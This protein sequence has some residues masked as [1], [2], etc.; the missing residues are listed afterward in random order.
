MS[1]IQED[2]RYDLHSCFH[3][4]HILLI[5]KFFMQ[6][7]LV[8]NGLNIW[9]LAVF[10]N[11]YAQGVWIWGCWR[12]LVTSRSDQTYVTLCWCCHMLQHFRLVKSHFITLRVQEGIA[13]IFMWR[14]TGV[15]VTKAPFANFSVSKIFD[16]AKVPVRFLESHSY[17]T[18]VTA[19]ELRRHQPNINVIFNS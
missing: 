7:F 12:N 5:F 19:A 4:S 17:L 2:H 6:L 1:S 9:F 10:C 11:S 18:G 8:Q 16:L 15:G 3:A 13:S 14:W